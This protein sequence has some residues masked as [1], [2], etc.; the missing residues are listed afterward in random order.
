MTPSHRLLLATTFLFSTALVQ[1]TNHPGG[2]PGSGGCPTGGGGPC[3]S[4]GGNNGCGGTSGSS[5]GG[6]GGLIV[7]SLAWQINVGLARYAKPS[8]LS[9]FSQGAYDMNGNLPTFKEIYG[10]YFSSSP[11][12]QIQI[13][14]ELSQ[15]QISATTFHPS[16]LFLQSEALFETLK[17]PAVDGLPEYIHQILT[18]DAFALIDVLPSPES[19]WRVRVWKR[20]AAPL[21]KSGG[22]YVTTNFVTKTPLTDVTFKRPDGSTAN[23]VLLYIQKET[24]GVSGTR[25]ITNEITQTLDSNGKPATVT[26]KLFSGEGTGGSLLSQENLTYSARGAKAWDYTITREVLT[27]SVSASGTIGGLTLT[28]KTQENYDDFST[29]VT[30]GNLGMKRLMSITEAYDVPGQSPQTTTHTYIDTPTNPSVH[31]RLQSSVRPDGSWVYNEYII[32]ANNPVSIVTEYSGWKDLTMDQREN[33]RKSVTTSSA[34][35]SL[36]ENF[37]AGQLVSKSK[38]TLTSQAT[39]TITTSEEWDGSAWHITTTG[40]FPDNAPVPSTGRIKWIENSDGTAATYSYSTVSGNLVTVSRTG[41]GSR[42]GITAGTEVKTTYGLGNIPIAEITKDISSGLN[43]EQWDTDLTTG[44]DIIG[45]PV[46]RIFNADVNDYD[47][48]QYA[49]C[50]LNFSRD[51]MGATTEYFRDGLKRVYK[52]VRKASSTSPEDTRFTTVAGLTTTQTRLRDGQSLF[53][54]STTRSLDGLS[55]TNLSPDANGDGNPETSS[56]VT[57]YSSTVGPVTTMTFPDGTTA[58]SQSFLDGSQKSST[59]QLGRTSTF[60]QNLHA[61]NGGGIVT[62]STAANSTQWSESYADALGRPFKTLLADGAQ[63]SATYYPRSA[64][65]GSR[66][67]MA[68]ST[69]PDGNTVSYAYNAEGEQTTTTSPMPNGQQSITVTEQDVV[70]DP[71]TGVAKRSRTT[72]NG[73][74]ISTSLSGTHGYRAKS[75]DHLAGNAISTRTRTFPNDGAWTITTTTPDGTKSVATYTH[76]LLVS[77]S[78]LNTENLPLA[79]STT[80]YDAF[81]RVLTQTDSRTG[82]TT[83]GTYLESGAVTSV[84]APGGRTTSF[85][86]DVMGRTLTT[87]APDSLDANG[88]TLS[89]ITTTVYDAAGQVI[90]TTGDQT[91]RVTYTYDVLGRQISMTTYGT[92]TATTTWQYSPTRGFL[93]A[94]RDA[95]NKGADYTYTAAGQIATRTW[96]RSSVAQPKVTTYSYDAGMLVE[97]NYSDTTP[98]ITL[99]YDNFGRPVTQSNGLASSTFTYSPATLAIDTETVTYTLPGKPAFTRVIDRSQDNLLRDTGWTLGTPTPSSAIENSVSYAFGTTDGRLTSISGGGLNPPSQFNYTYVP[100]TNL[101]ATVTSPAHTVSNVYEL[102]RDILA[103]KVNK[104]LDTTTVSSYFYTVNNFGQRTGVN[105]DGTAFAS[106]RNIAWGY[107][108]LGQVVKA[109]SNIAD[110]DRAYQYDGIGNRQSGGGLN[111]PSQTSYTVNA[112]NQYTTIGSL[113]PTHDDDGNKTSGPLPANVN[114]NSNL[115]WDGEN[116]LIQAQVTSGG[117]VT[118]VYDSQSRK[119]A[120]TIESNTKITVY[121]SWNPIAEYQGSAGV[122]PALTKTYTWG[123]DLSGSMQGAGGVGGLLMVTVGSTGSVDRYFPTFDGNGNVSE[124]LD[125]NGN[126]VAHYE[127]D[128]FGKTTV[129]NGSKAN[130]FAHRF[131]TKPLDVTTG[132]YYYGYRFYDPVTG[133]WPSRDPIEERGGVNLYAF[134]NNDGVN[135]W[136]RLGLRNSCT[137]C[138]GNVDEGCCTDKCTELC[139]INSGCFV[140]CVDVCIAGGVPTGLKAGN[141]P[142]ALISPPPT[143]PTIG[144]VVDAIGRALDSLLGL[145]YD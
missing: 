78:S 132:L 130:D 34:N 37:V 9:S 35:E 7:E 100:N 25:T 115:V 86:Y 114:A 137:D 145:F 36:V 61:E 118:Y 136:D 108:S 102:D 49:C 107:D 59:D 53:L 126:T 60:D 84:T 39:E 144:R 19:G 18:D 134:V 140:P 87:D 92:A 142:P 79:N 124:Y 15:P 112:L 72:V 85:T 32:S 99:T 52:V 104:K 94:K 65:A 106:T 77:S 122:P 63:S 33:A 131:S 120:E 80:T 135:K 27:S 31:G 82:T 45:R 93:L 12:Q 119:I 138:N 48:A 129:S 23:D 64:A 117:T 91:Y 67:K 127:Y 22:Y 41:A 90:E 89:N 26:T 111:P 54:G 71:F 5:T 2:G 128:P 105:K 51:R 110:Q 141:L 116:R 81:D 109:D 44:F 56:S 16:A 83:M 74:L 10:R 46:K 29:T 139:S 11:L 75:I 14:L 133:R 73:V 103:S 76:G 4:S 20:N 69:D 96:A 97:T 125:S 121:D 47:I 1:G 30:G 40:Y 3:G 66:G 123:M 8:S 58:S 42:S 6:A 17:K 98:D 57:V 62:R 88:N 101:I 24:I 95:A 21:T 70:N 50:G 143:G 28:A 55:S 113:N 13:S 68:S 38:T 43:I